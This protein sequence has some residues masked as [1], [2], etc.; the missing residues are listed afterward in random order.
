[1]FNSSK[2]DSDFYVLTEIGILSFKDDNFLNPLMLYP[3]GQIK[4]EVMQG[5]KVGGKD[6]VF[7]LFVG[8][9]QE[10]ILAVPDKVQYE[11]WVKALKTMI[12]KAKN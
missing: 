7:K 10:H 2:W 1:M 6:F 11:K 5:K 3:L 8:N 12:D 9:E 4:I